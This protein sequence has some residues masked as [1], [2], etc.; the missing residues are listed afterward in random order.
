MANL[1]GELTPP[2]CWLFDLLRPT[3]GAD[4]NVT[5]AR[6]EAK[7]LAKMMVYEFKTKL[8][9]VYLKFSRGLW[10]FLTQTEQH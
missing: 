8:A 3:L 6:W 5:A 10:L 4:P 2:Y 7:P 9:P 1:A